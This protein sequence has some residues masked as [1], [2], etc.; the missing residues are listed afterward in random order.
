M[1][2]LRIPTANINIIPIQNTLSFLSLAKSADKSL[3]IAATSYKTD[4][5]A[6][7]AFIPDIHGQHFT[8]HFCKLQYQSGYIYTGKDVRLAVRQDLILQ[9]LS[10]IHICPGCTGTAP[11]QGQVSE[12]SRR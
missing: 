3:L 2:G 4:V 6:F 7:Q 8:V 9:F 1:T 12:T 11:S 10:L 5:I